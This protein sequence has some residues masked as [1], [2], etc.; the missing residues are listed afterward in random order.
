MAANFMVFDGQKFCV[1]LSIAENSGQ[2]HS[3]HH[4]YTLCAAPFLP[5]LYNRVALIRFNNCDSTQPTL[6]IGK[7]EYISILTCQNER[8]TKNTLK[9]SLM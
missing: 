5:R 2:F 7:T 8:T 3:I 4:L 1:Y 9:M 6:I